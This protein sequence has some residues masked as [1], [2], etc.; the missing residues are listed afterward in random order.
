MIGQDFFELVV[1]NQKL[2]PCHFFLLQLKLVNIH[3]ESVVDGNQTIVLGLIWAIIHH[4]QVCEL[5]AIKSS[6]FVLYDF[7]VVQNR[8][9]VLS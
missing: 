1:L 2:N 5:F 6:M 3:R 4:Y 9:S 8:I 7:S